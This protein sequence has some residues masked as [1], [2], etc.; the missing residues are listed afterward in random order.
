MNFIEHSIEWVNGEIVEGLAFGVFGLALFVL[1]IVFWKFSEASG[2]KALV[3]PSLIIGLFFIIASGIGVYN[4]TQRLHAFAEA[5][6]EDVHAF[7]EKE[8]RRVEGFMSWYKY[9]FA[10]GLF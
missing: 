7:A 9:T 5:Y 3:T 2:A 8:K 4:N 6:Q 10:L 1:A